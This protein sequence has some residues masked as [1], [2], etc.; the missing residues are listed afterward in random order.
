MFG[1]NEVAGPMRNDDGSLLVNSIWPT[2]QGEGP[3]AGKA[4]V[5]LRLSKCNL[6]CYFC[7]TEFE[8]GERWDVSRVAADII[9]EA[10]EGKASPIRLLVITGGEPLLQNIIPLVEIMNRTGITVQIETAGTLYLEGLDRFF[11]AD[12]SIAGNAIVCSPKTPVIARRLKPLIA[13]L[14]YIIGEED[15]NEPSAPDG[16]PMASTQIEGQR[17]RI[18]RPDP[19]LSSACQIY[20]QPLDAQDPIKNSRNGAACA[21]VAMNHGYRVSFQMHKYLGVD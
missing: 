18:Y 14:K 2:I 13:A 5:F 16:L 3:D 6:R 12:R 19:E 17:V 11:A 20:V 9:R 7:D 8:K 1:R 15:A 10:T 4:A 21:E